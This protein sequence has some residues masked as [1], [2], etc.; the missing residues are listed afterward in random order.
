MSMSR[1][2]LKTNSM[3]SNSLKGLRRLGIKCS[4]LRLITMEGYKAKQARRKVYGA[5]SGGHQVQA[6]NSRPVRPHILNSSSNELWLTLVESYLPGKVIRNSLPRVCMGSWSPRY[7][8]PSMYPN[9]RLPESINHI[10]Y[11]NTLRTVRHSYHLRT[12]HINAGNCLPAATLAKHQLTNSLPK[13][14]SL[15]LATLTIFCTLTILNGQ[16][17][18]NFSCSSLVRLEP[19]HTLVMVPSLQPLLLQQH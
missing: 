6:K 3:F 13:D 5:K 16:T 11:T 15:Q 18:L 14:S 10:I 12:S 19:R 9:S 8:L 2:S 7:P 1:I 4:Q 17:N